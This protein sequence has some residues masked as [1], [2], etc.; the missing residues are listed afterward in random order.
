MLDVVRQYSK[1]STMELL[2]VPLLPNTI[3]PRRRMGMGGQ[4][5]GM[6]RTPLTLSADS[7]IWGGEAG[8]C[9]DERSEVAALT[10]GEVR[11]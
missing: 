2:P 5:D 10:T 8:K 9:S 1:A 3:R 6:P 4:W 11:E 7:F